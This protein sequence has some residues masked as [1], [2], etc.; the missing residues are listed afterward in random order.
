M[1]SVQGAV[2]KNWLSHKR[3]FS[4]AFQRQEELRVSVSETSRV[5][6]T[7]SMCRQTHELMV[8]TGAS[9]SKSVVFSES[10]E[11]AAGR[12][13]RAMLGGVEG[14]VSRKVR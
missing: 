3:W 2:A 1:E 13:T 10:E 11:T 14:L 12:H 7:S 9:G 5:L 4:D 6:R 8:L